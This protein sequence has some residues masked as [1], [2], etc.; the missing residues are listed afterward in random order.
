MIG[1]PGNTPVVVKIQ[2]FNP[3]GFII[4]RFIQKIRKKIV[5]YKIGKYGVQDGWNNS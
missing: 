4:R 1:F 3:T 5:I 2:L